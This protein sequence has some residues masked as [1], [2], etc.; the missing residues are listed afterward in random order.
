MSVSS[1]VFGYHVQYLYTLYRMIES[2]DSKEVF[3]PE[4]REDLDIYLNDQIIETIQ[5]K[6]YSGTIVYSDLFSKGKSTSLFSRGK[7]SLVYHHYSVPTILQ[8]VTRICFRKKL[9]Y[10]RF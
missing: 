9:F 2:A 3:V 8:V 6:C 7:D 10:Y 5:V 4:G 1:T